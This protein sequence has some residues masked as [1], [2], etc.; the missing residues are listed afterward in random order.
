MSYIVTAYY[1]YGT[2]YEREVE[3]LKKSLL[4]FNIPNDVQGV[5]NLGCWWKNTG[6]KPTFVKQMLIKHKPKSIIYV[7]CDAEFLRYPKLFE[8]F[9]DDV[10][11]YVFDRSCYK[12]GNGGTEVLSGTL[13]FRNNEKVMDLVCRWE[14]QCKKNPKV[15]DQ[16][17]LEKVLSGDFSLLPGEYCKI[18]DR[19]DTVVD[20]VIIHHQAS[21]KVRK[22]KWKL[23]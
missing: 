1:T 5:P 14:E 13:F 11:A 23:D 7:D 9:E 17:S 20:P 3:R 16:Q 21:R 2:L 22:N 12:C 15:F 4:T 10:G 18:F 8:V 6:Y 19:M